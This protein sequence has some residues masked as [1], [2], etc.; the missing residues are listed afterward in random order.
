MTSG[1]FVQRWETFSVVSV[2]MSSLPVLDLFTMVFSTQKNEPAVFFF[3]PASVL[4]CSLGSNEPAGARS[5][6]QLS[7]RKRS[8]TE[9]QGSS[10]PSERIFCRKMAWCWSVGVDV[11]HILCRVTKMGGW[12]ANICQWRR[13]DFCSIMQI[14]CSGRLARGK[15]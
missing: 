5:P 3:C 6:G 7:S 11:V 9:P 15:N 10:L 1:Q 2:S 14:Y 4:F 13:L 12:I 8:W